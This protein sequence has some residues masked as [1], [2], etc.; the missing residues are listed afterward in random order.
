M[1]TQR[2]PKTAILKRTPPTSMTKTDIRTMAKP[3][4][5]KK[6]IMNRMEMATRTSPTTITMMKTT[7]TTI[8]TLP[9]FVVFTLA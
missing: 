3:I 2:N 6:T 8:T 7:T 9:V 5:M 4:P 1:H